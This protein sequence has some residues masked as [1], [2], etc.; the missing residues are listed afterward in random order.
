[1]RDKIDQVREKLEAEGKKFDLRSKS[2]AYAE[3]LE[4]LEAVGR[5]RRNPGTPGGVS[6]GAATTKSGS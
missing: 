5:H 1:M 2:D 4:L 6:A 3:A